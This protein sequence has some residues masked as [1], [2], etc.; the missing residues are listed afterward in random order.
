MN[1]LM[2]WTGC[3]LGLLGSL[4]VAANCRFSRWG[5]VAYL[6]SNTAWLAYSI[7]IG[8][9]GLLLQQVGF[10][11]TGLIGLWRWFTPTLARNRIV[12]SG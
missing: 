8:V 10:I 6:L 12:E 2:Q 5:F 7:L 1:N 11:I 9:P 4:L 3:A